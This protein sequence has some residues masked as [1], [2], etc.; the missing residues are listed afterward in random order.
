MY[1]NVNFIAVVLT[2]LSDW[3]EGTTMKHPWTEGAAM[4]CLKWKINS[5]SFSWRQK[6]VIIC[7]FYDAN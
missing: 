1:K 6:E 5:E 2:S 4:K 7:K 3:N